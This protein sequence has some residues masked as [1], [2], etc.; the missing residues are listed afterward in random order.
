MSG[1]TY[2]LLL[3]SV[4]RWLTDVGIVWLVGICAYRILAARASGS[5]ASAPGRRLESGLRRQAGAA[6]TLL[7]VATV[8]RLYAQTYSSFGLDEPVSVELMRLVAEQTRWGGRW[9]LQTGVVVAAALAATFLLLQGGGRRRWFLLCGSALAMVGL[10]PTTG[11]AFAFSGGVV[12]PMALQIVHLMSAGIW[13][14]TL[15]VLL[16]A[17][18]HAVW[19]RPSDDGVTVAR[20]VNRFSPVA[21]VAATLLG[22]TGVVTAI[23]YVDETRQLWGTTYGRVLLSKTGLFAVTAALG[24]YNWRR[25]RPRIGEPGGVVRLRRSGT[26]ELLVAATVLAVTAWLV[27]LPMPHE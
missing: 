4:A 17:G 23:L 14:G 9:R 10:A 26:A 5:D 21:L 22:G 18:V 8:A 2:A 20:L 25:V 19:S 13:L 15:L 1:E 3:L 7:M 16:S 6:V 27:H 24:A 11:H 12:L